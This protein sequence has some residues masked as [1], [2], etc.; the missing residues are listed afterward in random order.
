ME[1]FVFSNKA[2]AEV[3]LT[4]MKQLIEWYGVASRA[5]MKDIHGT[6]PTPEDKRFGW[7]DLS[8]AIIESDVIE[9]QFVLALPKAVRLE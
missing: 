5:D 9:Q 8:N 7:N 1:R 4:Q 3:A 2:R 6:L